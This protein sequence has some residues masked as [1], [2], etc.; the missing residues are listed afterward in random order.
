MAVLNFANGL[1]C[2]LNGGYRG[3]V[4][5]CLLL[6]RSQV[7][8]NFWWKVD[9]FHWERFDIYGD[10]GSEQGPLTRKPLLRAEIMGD[11]RKEDTHKAM[12]KVREPVEWR[13]DEVVTR[14]GFIDFKRQ[15]KLLHCPV[16]IFYRVC[17]LWMNCRTCLYRHEASQFSGLQPPSIQTYL[18]S[19]RT[20]VYS[21]DANRRY[22]L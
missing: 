15:M 10:S 20:S 1:I 11:P 2:N 19:F 14:F 21:F 6:K 8:E 18:S 7:F 12:S 13:L 9:T 22:H 16:N 4:Y 17:S 3:S 5:D